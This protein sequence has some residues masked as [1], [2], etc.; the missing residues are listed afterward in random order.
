MT[1]PG[2]VDKK[3]LNVALFK[4]ERRV[5]FS[6][7]KYKKRW[8][9][10]ILGIVMCSTLSDSKENEFLDSSKCRVGLQTPF[11]IIAICIDMRS[12]ILTFSPFTASFSGL[13]F[14]LLRLRTKVKKLLSCPLEYASELNEY[15][16]YSDCLLPSKNNP[17][18]NPI[19]INKTENSN[20]MVS[21]KFCCAFFFIVVLWCVFAQPCWSHSP[22][23][24]NSFTQC[25]NLF[26]L[27]LCW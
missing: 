24:Q 18:E 13:L 3:K 11:G 20:K 17:E 4:E 27:I 9:N 14:I 10:G 26:G 2:N 1:C 23:H 8:H 22:C 7:V 16:Y 5:L 21:T 12:S 19:W 15:Y 6:S 25:G